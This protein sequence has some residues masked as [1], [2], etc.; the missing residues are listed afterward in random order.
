MLFSDW[1]SLARVIVVGVPVYLLLIFLLRIAGKHSLAKTNAYGL[2]ITV[3]LGSALASAVLTKEVALA[4]AL[5]AMAIL[6]A[7]QYL[8]SLAIS[9]SERAQRV[10]TEQ[11][12]F[13]VQDGRIAWETLRRQRVSEAE[14]LAAIRKHGLGCV[15]DVGA[16]VLEA[17][18]S[19]SVI[20]NLGSSRSALANVR[21]GRRG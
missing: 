9:R 6:L 8:L 11:P 16:V 7:L 5:L 13:L 19:F 4:E 18:G 21:S 15:E 20:A 3:S 2:V 14:V 10:F 12:T 1:H 17:D